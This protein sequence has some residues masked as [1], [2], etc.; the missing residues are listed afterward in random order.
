MVI[1]NLQPCEYHSAACSAGR[2]LRDHA[3]QAAY[4]AGA[5]N[6]TASNAVT[7]GSET[8][9]DSLGVPI[10]WTSGASDELP[11][12]EKCVISIA[13]PTPSAFSNASLAV[14]AS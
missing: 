13:I 9:A 1:D 12:T 10:R 11:S 7:A 14:Q 5:S 4:P 6:Q 2:A 3:T 8:S